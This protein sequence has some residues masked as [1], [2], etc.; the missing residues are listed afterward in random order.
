MIVLALKSGITFM[1]ARP[2]ALPRFSTAAGRLPRSSLLS[3]NPRVI[4][5]YLAPQRFSSRVHHGPA[6][7]VQH[8]PSG[9]ISGKTELTL[10]K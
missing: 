1:R 6:E 10:Q 3:A 9:L 8:H 4:N 5:F 7:F 2:E